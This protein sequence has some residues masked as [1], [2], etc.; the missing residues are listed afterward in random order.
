MMY[1]FLLDK[2]GAWPSAAIIGLIAS[3]VS[4]T[5]TLMVV[6][7]FDLPNKLEAF[8]FSLVCPLIVAVPMSFKAMQT[9]LKI[10]QSKQELT[11]LNHQLE[12]ALAEVKELSGLLP[13]CASCK[14]I[15]NDEGYW[16]S[17]ES[18][19]QE[20]SQAQFTHSICPECAARAR[21]EIRS[22]ARANR[23]GESRVS[24]GEG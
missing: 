21:D 16:D 7:T 5:I 12:K 24:E 6:V 18:Y 14:K 4:V 22:M 2:W 9:M 11:E 15:R 8:V 3:T 1:R 17:I 20:H 19:I 13:I 23:Q 10:E